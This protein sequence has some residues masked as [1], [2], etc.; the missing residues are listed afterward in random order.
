MIKKNMFELLQECCTITHKIGVRDGFQ[1]G[2][3][4]VPPHPQ[5][6]TFFNVTLQLLPSEEDVISSSAP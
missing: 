2:A 6:F 1:K 5:L 4:T 3:S